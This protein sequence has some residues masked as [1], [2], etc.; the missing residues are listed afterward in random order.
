MAMASVVDVEAYDR[1]AV[2][3]ANSPAN[4]PVE[5]AVDVQPGGPNRVRF[6]LVRSD[7][8]GDDLTF[9]VHDSANPPRALNDTLLLVGEGSLSLL[10]SP[11]DLLLFTNTTGRDA[12]IEIL[13]GRLAT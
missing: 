4:A 8:Y 10:E 3:V 11:L 13:A 1:I 9:K 6:L 5:V 2:K 7:A 12:N